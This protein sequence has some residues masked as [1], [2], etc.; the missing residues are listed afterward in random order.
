MSRDDIPLEVIEHI[1][2]HHHLPRTGVC[3]RTETRTQQPLRG[4]A[5]PMVEVGQ[6]DTGEAAGVVGPIHPRLMV[7]ERQ[8]R[9]ETL[10]MGEGVEKL[11]GR[12][13]HA[14]GVGGFVR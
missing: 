4:L 12:P 1:L 10:L 5:L 13:A 8:A 6:R 9:A 7:G 11:S 3:R 2:D 14:V